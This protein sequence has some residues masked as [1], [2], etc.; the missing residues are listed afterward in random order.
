MLPMLDAGHDLSP[1]R[2]VARE[3]VGDHHARCDALLL[4]QLAQQPLG[5][6]G[7]AP[8]LNQDGGSAR[9]VPD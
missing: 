5:R 1:G 3:F 4:E 7:I 8:A 2:A 6:L 9:C